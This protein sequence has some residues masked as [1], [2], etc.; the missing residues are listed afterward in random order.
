MRKPKC[1]GNHNVRVEQ[2]GKETYKN[3]L[4]TI[5]YA[6]RIPPISFAYGLVENGL[7]VGIVSFG[8]PASPQVARSVFPSDAKTVLEL[9]RLVL[10]TPTKNA[11]SF[12]VGCALKLLPPRVVVSYADGKMGHVGYIYQAT[13]FWY[14]GEATAHDHEYVID[15]KP[16]HPRTLASR[17]IT[18][19]KQWAAENGVQT[20]R[21]HGKHRYV[22]IT[23]NRRQTK[24][25]IKGIKWKLSKC[26]P[27]GA[28]AHYQIDENARAA[29]VGRFKF[30]WE[31]EFKLP[32]EHSLTFPWDKA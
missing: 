7:T 32:W 17:G 1:L 21:P 31:K 20:V 18:N 12:L 4:L 9:N 25:L 8:S 11:A 19:P 10:L 28:A 26:Y 5:H 30:P 29:L 2:I 16:V 15:G 22:F 6:K 24:E 14:A 13:N 27:K 23:G 3:W